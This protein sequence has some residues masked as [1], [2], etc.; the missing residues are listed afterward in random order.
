MY[1][2]KKKFV[3][4]S[5]GILIIDFDVTEVEASW[6]DNIPVYAYN[7]LLIFISIIIFQKILKWIF[8]WIKTIKLLIRCIGDGN[9]MV[10]MGW[11]IG[12]IK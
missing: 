4:S 7:K 1:K 6:P 3:F 5:V 9:G 10:W 12:I 8:A 2:L 11:E